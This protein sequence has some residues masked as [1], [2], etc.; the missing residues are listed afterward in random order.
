MT[1]RPS[2]TARYA[3]TALTIFALVAALFM[4]Y[5]GAYFGL[6]GLNSPHWATP[7]LRGYRYKWIATTFEPAA[8]LESQLRG[9]E[10]R[11]E[12]SYRYYLQ[13]TINGRR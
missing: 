1:I 13:D 5:A 6:S 3:T 7:V 11:V 12:Q 4:A 2:T 9:R 8:W 10:V